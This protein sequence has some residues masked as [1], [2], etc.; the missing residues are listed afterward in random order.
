M[1]TNDLSLLRRALLAIALGLA[2]ACGSS[3]GTPPDG[4]PTTPS[5]DPGPALER[6]EGWSVRRRMRLSSGTDV[7]L[8]EQLASFTVAAQGASR[9]RRVDASGITPWD[10]PS[11]LFIADAALHPSGAVT[12]LLLD[13]NLA[14]WLARLGPDLALLDLAQLHDPEIVQDPFPFDG[15]VEQ[16]TD[17]TANGLPKDPVRIA[18]DR[19][20]AVVTAVTPLNSVLLYRLAFSTH[21]EAPRRALILPITPHLPFLPI[22]GTF[23]TFGAMWSSFR[24]LVD[25]DPDGNAYVAFWAGPATLRSHNAFTGDDLKKI[26]TEQFSQDS[27]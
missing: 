8:E 27:D 17:L 19:E 10:A 11:G 12:A 15:G 6:T 2:A 13:A 7:V 4:G 20:E 26:A 1:A 14:V 18:S 5:V 3:A 9:I 16:P 23:D 24:A 21:W 25:I 22:G